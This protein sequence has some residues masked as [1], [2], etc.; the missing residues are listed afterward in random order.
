MK[1]LTLRMAIFMAGVTQRELARKAGIPEAHLSMAI[2]GKYNLDD[3]QKKKIANA[4]D[5]PEKQVFSGLI[6]ML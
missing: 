3:L 6:A 4:L 2:H 5:M 1:N